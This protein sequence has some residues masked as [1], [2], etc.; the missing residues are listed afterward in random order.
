MN[1]DLSVSVATAE[2]SAGAKKLGQPVPDSNFVSDR[3]SS[4]PQPAHR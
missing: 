4:F 1:Q 3:K 2:G